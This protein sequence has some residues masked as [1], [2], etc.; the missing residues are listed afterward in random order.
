MSN[1]EYFQQGDILIERV[2]AAPTGETVPPENGRIILAK[3]ELTGHAH[4]IEDI[5]GIKF[6]KGADG[7]FY[8]VL[9]EVRDLVHPEHR[10][11]TLPPGSY[12]VRR[13]REYD[14]FTE[15]SRPVCE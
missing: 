13:V 9:P 1:A 3:G 11:V 2:D 12:R 5:A 14:H 4:A 15:E 7:N 10:T 6:I 8:L